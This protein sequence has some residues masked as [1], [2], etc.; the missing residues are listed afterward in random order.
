MIII[1]S[2]S[3]KKDICPFF[4]SMLFLAHL[5]SINAIKLKS[6]SITVLDCECLSHIDD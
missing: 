1:I 2:T 5:V 3:L 4:K 6:K